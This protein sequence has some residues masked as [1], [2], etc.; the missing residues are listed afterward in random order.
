MRDTYVNMGRKL[1]GLQLPSHGFV[2]TPRHWPYKGRNAVFFG[3]YLKVLAVGSHF[4][5]IWLGC[6]GTL[7]LLKELYFADIVCVNLCGNYP[8]PYFGKYDL[9]NRANDIS[10]LTSQLCVSLGFRYDRVESGLLQ[11]RGF[12]L[13]PE[14]LSNVVDELHNI[15]HDADIIFVPREGDFHPDHALTARGILSKFRKC[16]IFEYEI[17]A[18][19]R[20]PFAPN[21]FVDL[22]LMSNLGD[23]LAEI[24]WK[25]GQGS[26]AEKKAAILET[27]FKNIL[28]QEIPMVF[29]R[30]NTLGKMAYRAAENSKTARYAEAFFSELII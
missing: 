22:S 29:Q 18:F 27:A 5:D 1:Q 12:E 2:P 14:K 11:D 3:R 6:A 23:D 8:H 9:R 25:R 13:N 21:I 20:S 10:T 26:F 17:K 4:D 15:Y 7:M 16:D 19:R 28:S 30:D 24:P